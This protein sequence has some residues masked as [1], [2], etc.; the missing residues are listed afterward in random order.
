MDIKNI[1]ECFDNNI[2]PDCLNFK[3][4]KEDTIDYEKFNYLD[5]QEY[6]YYA[7]RFPPGFD[8][9][10]GFNQYLLTIADNNKKT[11]PLKEM[12]KLKSRIE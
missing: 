12:L 4:E 2:V 7:N 11:T 6:E 10:P 5:Y 9:I 1:D 3:I 8:W